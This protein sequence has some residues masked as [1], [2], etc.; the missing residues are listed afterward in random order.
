MNITE[1]SKNDNWLLIEKKSEDMLPY[2]VLALDYLT[3][4][5]AVP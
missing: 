1:S 2:N 3:A 4:F 5:M